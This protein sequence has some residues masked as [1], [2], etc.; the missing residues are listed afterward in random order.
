MK[1]FR[2]LSLVLALVMILASCGGAK[3][4]KKGRRKDRGQERLL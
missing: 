3:R 1:K 2:L 4:R